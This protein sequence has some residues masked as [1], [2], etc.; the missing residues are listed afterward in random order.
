MGRE[1]W[2]SLQRERRQ[3]PML[4]VRPLAAG[5]GSSEPWERLRREADVYQRQEALAE[6]LK[7][8]A[9]P[10]VQPGAPRRVR[11]PEGWSIK[12]W[13]SQPGL[14]VV[15]YGD[16]VEIHIEWPTAAHPGNIGIAI[17]GATPISMNEWVRVSRFKRLNRDKR[18]WAGWIH[19]VLAPLLQTFCESL[20][21]V[22][23]SETI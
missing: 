7:S 22:L 11:P 4:Q 8:A 13:A 14:W 15:G 3:I 1:L 6:F 5:G 2:Q 9:W 19:Q 21:A 10:E 20:P 17:V 18:Y 23:G 12:R 16:A